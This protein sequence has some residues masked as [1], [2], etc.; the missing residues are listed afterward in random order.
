VLKGNLS[1]QKKKK[2][3]NDLLPDLLQQ[4]SV[5]IVTCI[6]NLRIQS[7][8]N[9]FLRN[10]CFVDL[11]ITNI[12]TATTSLGEVFIMQKIYDGKTSKE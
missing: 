6:H 10:T 5:T 11:K 4:R 1:N 8:Y 12:L 9:I 2:Q 3:Q 7:I